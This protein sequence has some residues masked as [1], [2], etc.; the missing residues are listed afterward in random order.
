MFWH[1]A[2]LPVWEMPESISVGRGKRWK[3][4][5]A[6][7][8]SMVAGGTC[9]RWQGGLCPLDCLLVLAL[10]VCRLEGLYPTLYIPYPLQCPEGHAQTCTHEYRHV[11]AS[12]HA[13][14]HHF[15]LVP[16]RL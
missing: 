1:L 13:Q 10:G 6:K 8:T 7:G 3:G 12:T 5:E 11:H 15:L 2:W 16:I 14:M 9:I 4:E